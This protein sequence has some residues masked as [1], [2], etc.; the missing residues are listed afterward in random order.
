MRVSWILRLIFLVVC[1]AQLRLLIQHHPHSHPTP[2]KN[3]INSLTTRNVLFLVTYHKPPAQRLQELL[4]I[5]QS[6]LEQFKDNSIRIDFFFVCTNSFTFSDESPCSIESMHSLNFSYLILNKNISNHH[7]SKCPYCKKTG[8]WSWS[9]YMAPLIALRQLEYEFPDKIYDAVW[10][11]EPDAEYLGNIADWLAL[12]EKRI[13]SSNTPFVSSL[14][15][16]NVSVASQHLENGM[17]AKIEKKWYRWGHRPGP[18]WF[19]AFIHV[20]RLS[21]EMM[22]SME[23]NLEM[24]GFCENF[25]PY[26]CQHKIQ[27]PCIP[28]SLLYKDVGFFNT[29]NNKFAGEE[30]AHRFALIAARKSLSQ[31]K[32][33]HPLKF[34]ISWRQIHQ[35]NN[36]FFDVSNGRFNGSAF[37]LTKECEKP[38]CSSKNKNCCLYVKH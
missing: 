15:F 2:T 25:I 9:L 37:C 17:Y 29:G 35:Q 13:P 30:S 22:E 16:P 19:G 5:Y 8:P 34:E 33:Y 21:S 20:M 28:S 1:C 3:R 38:A 7:L 11:T 14:V 32:W 24:A 4:T 6:Q 12:Q 18:L 26:I 36:P 31:D 10:A 23:Q 27:T